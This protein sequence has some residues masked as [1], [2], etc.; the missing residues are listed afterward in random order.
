MRWNA[1]FS[2]VGEL[3][4]RPCGLTHARDQAS[5]CPAIGIARQEARRLRQGEEEKHAKND[6][7]CASNKKED[8]P[9]I[10]RKDGGGK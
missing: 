8:R 2:A 10:G 6:G 3:S 5:H 4:F 1:G 7:N 9:S